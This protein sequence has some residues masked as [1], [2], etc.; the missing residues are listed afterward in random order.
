MFVLTSQYDTDLRN[1]VNINGP[2][3]TRPVPPTTDELLTIFNTLES[4]KMMSDAI[5]WHPVK[6]KLLFGQQADP[7]Y[8]VRFK[9]VKVPGSSVSDTEIKSKVVSVINQYFSLSNWDFGSSFFFTE[10]AAY[11]HTQLATMVGTVVIVP[12]SGGTKFGDLFE[13][14]ADPDEIFISCA[15]VT[16]IDIVQALSDTSIGITNG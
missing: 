4:Y 8:Q 3:S 10:L 5:V 1:W 2:T 9:V 12:L 6:Y 7:T 15:R 11:I 14:T 16:D 13:I